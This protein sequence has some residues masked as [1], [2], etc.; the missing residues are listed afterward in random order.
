ME[1][2]RNAFLQLRPC[3]LPGCGIPLCFS[4]V[5]ESHEGKQDMSL[6]NIN[7]YPM[8]QWPDTAGFIGTDIVEGLKAHYLSSYIYERVM[9]DVRLSQCADND[10][11]A[12][13]GV[14]L[15]PRCSVRLRG[16]HQNS[17]FSSYWIHPEMLNGSMTNVSDEICT[18]FFWSLQS[19]YYKMSTPVFW[20]WDV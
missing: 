13:H 17:T 1:R 18:D 12:V 5:L 8:T 15:R 3:S 11:S 16:C 19:T 20:F 9:N 2:Q 14:E 4:N 7:H 10:V 6:Q